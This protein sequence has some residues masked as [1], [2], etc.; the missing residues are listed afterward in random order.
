MADYA[1]WY[2][3][4]PWMADAILSSIHGRSTEL[5][6]ILAGDIA[7]AGPFLHPLAKSIGASQNTYELA[8]LLTALKTASS[9]IKYEVLNGLNDGRAYASGLRLYH[10]EATA[11]LK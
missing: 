4:T 5:L 2:V 3:D 11:A 1:R 9:G 6:V 7:S 8:E 10:S